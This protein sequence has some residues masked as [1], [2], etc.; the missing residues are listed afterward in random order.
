MHTQY[1]YRTSHRGSRATPQTS[2]SEFHMSYMVC[3]MH[4]TGTSACTCHRMIQAQRTAPRRENLQQQAGHP[5]RYIVLQRHRFVSTGSLQGTRYCSLKS[6]KCRADSLRKHCESIHIHIHIY[7]IEQRMALP[8]P[9]ID[10]A[11]GIPAAAVQYSLVAAPV[12]AACATHRP[13]HKLDYW[14]DGVEQC[15]DTTVDFSKF[16]AAAGLLQFL[17]EQQ[18]L[19]TS[20]LDIC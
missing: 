7:S 10:A 3:I 18:E 9:Y 14:Q 1:T 5:A 11:P 2:D 16:L 12:T 17:L 8:I 19:A 15:R 6:G 4:T 20:F 13:L